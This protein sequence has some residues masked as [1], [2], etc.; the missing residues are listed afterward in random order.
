M[1]E[2]TYRRVA[3]ELRAEIEA[4][5]YPLDEPLPT[6]EA[7]GK[8]FKVS[9]QTAHN[10]IRALA[11]EGVIR[12]VH[13]QG[14]FIRERPRERAVIR[15]RNVYRDELGYYFD[16]NAKDWRAVG[17][18]DHRIEAPPNHVADLLGTPRGDNVLVRDR[19]MGPQGAEQARQI[20]VSYLPLSLVAAIPAV[21]GS[22]TGPGGI[23][24]RI[25]EHFR[26]P[27]SWRET[28]SAREASDEEE[29]RL[30]VSPGSS[31]LIVTRESWVCRDGEKVVVEVNETRMP[32][33]GFAVSYGV[34]RDESAAWPRNGGEA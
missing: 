7:L 9:K 2:A 29:D 8:R 4:G 25:E 28:I 16:Q 30:G 5:E 34:Q 19:A 1:A 33:E 26:A 13:R 27:L 11:S 6:V 24:D 21:G 14:T 12:V 15:D 18:P 23:Y 22:S 10:A 32:A 20:A 31:V 17:A 3:R